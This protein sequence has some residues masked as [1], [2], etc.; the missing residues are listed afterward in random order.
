[1]IPVLVWTDKRYMPRLPCF[2]PSIREAK[3]ERSSG[4]VQCK[5]G[6]GVI[7]RVPRPG[8]TNGHGGFAVRRTCPQASD[9]AGAWA[10]SH[11]Q[12][13]CCQRPLGGDPAARTG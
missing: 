10:S 2:P 1:M 5:A 3:P 11:E 8:T 7:S 6:G 12:A 9:K 4:A 13:L